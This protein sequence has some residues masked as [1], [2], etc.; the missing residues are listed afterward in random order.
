MNNSLDLDP[1]EGI[2]PRT[3]LPILQDFKKEDV[4]GGKALYSSYKQ[5]SL[6]DKQ[7]TKMKQWFRES[8]SS[9][10]QIAALAAARNIILAEAQ[11]C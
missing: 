4:I 3:M 1:F 10:Q 7:I 11:K 5:S 8:L 9:A 2:D 6:E